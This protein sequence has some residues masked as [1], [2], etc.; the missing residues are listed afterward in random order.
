[1]F[2]T[3]F[4]QGGHLPLCLLGI[5]GAGILPRCETSTNHP[6]TARHGPVFVVVRV[7][8]RKPPFSAKMRKIAQG[9][10]DLISGSFLAVTSRRRRATSLDAPRVR[11]SMITYLWWLV[12][13]SSV[14]PPDW[15]ITAS[16]HHPVFVNATPVLVQ[17][18]IGETHPWPHPNLPVAVPS[19]TTRAGHQ[20]R[21]GPGLTGSP[22]PLSRHASV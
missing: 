18:R 16:C 2:D 6:V 9:S 17:Q 12:T 1:M 8:I 19:S 21:S 14:P 4:Q 11:R 3:R 22:G 20:H 5:Q 10:P 15:P 13:P 7:H